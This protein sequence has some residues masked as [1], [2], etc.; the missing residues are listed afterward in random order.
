MKLS[1]MTNKEAFKA[2]AQILPITKEILKDKE[3]SN[4]YTRRFMATSIE[5]DVMK[6]EKQIFTLDKNMDL[7]AYILERHD[8]KI[9]KILAI[10][11]GKKPKEIEE[12]RFMETVGQLTEALND[13]ALVKLFTA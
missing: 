10:L 7:I 6:K 3:L 13:E 11:N 2:M 4:I 1:E 12:Q 9:F 8:K 5:R